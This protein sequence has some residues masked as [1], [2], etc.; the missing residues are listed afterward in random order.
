MTEVSK[1]KGLYTYV[2]GITVRLA[3]E[4][5][6]EGSMPLGSDVHPADL[7]VPHVVDTVADLLARMAFHR[8]E[9]E[10]V[11]NNPDARKDG[12]W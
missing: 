6:L 8:S 4:T 9:W 12:P 7:V 5:L 10:R 1:P 11:R 3:D 2:V